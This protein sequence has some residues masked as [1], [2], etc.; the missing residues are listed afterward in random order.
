MTDEL[1]IIGDI[2][3]R[4][5]LLQDLC[6][7]L[8]PSTK[9]IA[10]GD[11]INKGPDSRMVL[12]FLINRPKSHLLIGNHEL[13]LLMALAEL[14][15]FSKLAKLKFCQ[16]WLESKGVATLQSYCPQL[17]IQDDPLKA[18]YTFK[19]E[20]EDLGHR[21]YLEHCPFLYTSPGL[22]VTHAP[23]N[24]SWLPGF[25]DQNSLKDRPCF[26]GYNLEKNLFWVQSEDAIKVVSNLNLNLWDFVS[27]RDDPS[28]LPHYQHVFGHMRSWGYKKFGGRK[29]EFAN[30]C[31]DA[32][33][34]DKLNGILWP[35]RKKKKAKTIA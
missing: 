34:K 14:D 11:A 3:G 23:A 9:I 26:L 13:N 24:L 4:Y 29:N 18:L 12:E 6:Y 19:K 2:A 8:H 17:N 21:Q 30:L 27:C 28:P 7:G 16:Y 10:V 15:K 31:I 25:L 35:S 33:S 1:L 22:V 20:L 5:H 32:K